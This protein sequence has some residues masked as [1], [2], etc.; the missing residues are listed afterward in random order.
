MLRGEGDKA[1]ASMKSLEEESSRK[2]PKANIQ[3][4][5]NGESECDGET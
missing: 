3:S 5:I 2:K 1:L 4:E